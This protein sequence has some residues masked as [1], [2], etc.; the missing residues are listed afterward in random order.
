MIEFWQLSQLTPLFSA[1][2]NPEWFDILVPA[3][4]GCTGNWALNDNSSKKHHFK[5]VKLQLDS[6]STTLRLTYLAKQQ[7]LTILST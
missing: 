4:L 1:A 2:V 7:P 5:V 6:I 3:Y